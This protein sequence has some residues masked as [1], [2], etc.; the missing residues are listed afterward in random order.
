MALHQFRVQIKVKGEKVE[1]HL[2]N[3][4]SPDFIKELGLLSSQHVSKSYTDNVMAV[5]V[6]HGLPM[7][8][9]IEKKRKR[10]PETMKH[11]VEKFTTFEMINTPQHLEEEWFY[12]T[13]TAMESYFKLMGGGFATNKNFSLDIERKCILRKGKEVAWIEH[14]I[15]DVFIICLCSNQVLSKEEVKIITH[16]WETMPQ[17]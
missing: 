13:W 17:G 5:C 6:S 14:F 4:E 7:G 10:S 15:I 8:I 12:R 1:L 16:G 3:M 9:D 11:F 2:F